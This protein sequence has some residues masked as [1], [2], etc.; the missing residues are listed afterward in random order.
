MDEV[1]AILP[2]GYVKWTPRERVA[3]INTNTFRITISSFVDMYNFDAKSI[4]RE[5]VHVIT[6]DLRRIPFSAY[7]MLHR[8]GE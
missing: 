4:K 1:M 3:F 8:G 7:N 5:C 6:P 2:A